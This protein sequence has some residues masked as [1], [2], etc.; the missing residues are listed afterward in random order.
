MGRVASSSMAP[1]QAS[2]A[3][4]AASQGAAVTLRTAFAQAK[5]EGLRF[6]L[7][8]TF[9]GFNALQSADAVKACRIAAIGTKNEN[10]VFGYLGHFTMQHLLHLSKEIKAVQWR[11]LPAQLT[12]MSPDNQ[13]ATLN[14]T[15][16]H[17]CDAMG[18]QVDRRAALLQ[19]ATAIQKHVWKYSAQLDVTPLFIQILNQLDAPPSPALPAVDPFAHTG[20]PGT[21]NE[22]FEEPPPL[23]VAFL[24]AGNEQLTQLLKN[25][26]QDA[27]A[28]AFARLATN[29]RRAAQGSQNEIA[30]L[31][32]LSGL[33]QS[34]QINLHAEDKEVRPLALPY[35]LKN[36]NESTMGRIVQFALKD[37]S[38]AA[39]AEAEK[40]NALKEGF[41]TI[42]RHVAGTPNEALA[43]RA[44]ANVL[45]DNLEACLAGAHERAQ[46]DPETRLLSDA[47]PTAAQLLPPGVLEHWTAVFGKSL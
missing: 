23:A 11:L 35:L 39:S 2:L 8:E 9:E 20:W 26:F 37:F 43:V 42:L 32:A 15:L 25:A 19:G 33:I 27:N 7:K 22:M 36:A 12:L 46:G 31:A 47:F 10:A 28:N 14:K 1:R 41:H 45:G 18:P 13:A 24:E 4:A 3:G 29:F 38:D 16:L 40:F 6:I 5:E 21:E 30:V 17:Y 44:A 34:T